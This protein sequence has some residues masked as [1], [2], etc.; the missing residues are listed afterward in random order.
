[1]TGS[2]QQQAWQR[3]AEQL[4]A[5]IDEHNRRY[6]LED[7]PLV[8]D[9]DYDALMQRLKELEQAHPQLITADSPTQRVGATPSA[10]F[11]QITHLTPMLS[12]DNAL[13][14]EV[15]EAFVERVTTRL[16]TETSPAIVAEPKLDGIAVSLLYEDSIFV[17]AATRGDGRVG[18]DISA[19]V[20]TIPSVPM[21]LKLPI[22]GRFEVRGEV[23]M[24]RSGFEKLNEAS[25][26]AG[27]KV[28]ANPRNAAA[29]SLRQL[30]SS[31]TAARPLIFMAYSLG[32]VDT[33]ITA[34]NHFDTLLQLRELGF[35]VN[36]LV[37]QLA[38]IYS[39]YDYYRRMALRRDE[40]DY[41]IDG[42]VY[43]IDSLAL[44]A[45]LGFV[46][47][48]P[49]WAIARKFPAQERTTLLRGVDFQVGRTGA[50]TPVARLDPVLVG[51]VN[52]SNA[53][54]HNR[55]EIE[56]LGVC[57]GDEVIVRRAGDVI[58]QIV[59]VSSANGGAHI[60]FPEQCPECGSLLERV[61]TEAATRC[62]AGLV[63]PAQR[64]ES[65]EHFASRKAMNIDG[66][67]SKLVAQLVETELLHT[68]ADIFVLEL[69]QLIGL[70][71]MAEKSANKLLQA[72]RN[73]RRT[74]LARFIYAL[75]IREV[76]EATAAALAAHFYDL[77]PLM[78]ATVDALLEVADVGP[79]VAAHIHAFFANPENRQVVSECLAAGVSW[80]V[81]EA[82]E[83]DLPLAGQTIVLT[84]S[85]SIFTREEASEKLMALGAKVAGSVSKNTT[86]VYAGENAGSK[87][88]KAESLGVPVCSEQDLL[89][90][91]EKF[92]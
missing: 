79:V 61:E 85:L 49:R 2:D 66:L 9:Q 86:A 56:R 14:N 39:C 23:V 80:P 22:A 47:R 15:L 37:E 29:G 31:I 5:Q 40:L 6:Y 4:R 19:N 84:G 92:A 90:L 63:C 76:G 32:F 58:P 10:G 51:G 52:V 78:N 82:A 91:L 69:D 53:T 26:V 65:L 72:I 73:S 67:G 18:E 17:R 54:L 62:P 7:S 55:D 87:R 11:A 33:Q 43:K 48:A 60:L 25:R 13:S 24:S 8:T 38:D 20:R 75:G 77:P 45:R 50:V 27:T 44:Q 64:R 3:E 35:V 70:E 57:L 34:E 88:A 1:M 81:V 83:G 36:E 16:K 89:K 68:P 12:L 71:R 42:I 74:S 46:S 41:D 59:A 21:R 30:D 28:F